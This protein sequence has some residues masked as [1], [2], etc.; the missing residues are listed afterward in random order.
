M[1][2]QRLRG[3][4]DAVLRESAVH[5]DAD[6]L[7]MAAHLLFAVPAGIADAAV[8]VGIDCDV[9]ADLKPGDAFADL[10]N[11]AGVFVPEHDG[12]MYLGAA[13]LT[14]VDVHVRA[15]DAAGVVPDDDGSGLCL[16]DRLLAHFK[17]LISKEICGFHRN[18]P[19]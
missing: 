15:A 1:Q 17:R 7:H 11:H 14:A 13:G 5:R 10:R 16:G 8:N 6:R 9:V 2:A 3:G 12:R 18:H 4:H 19:F